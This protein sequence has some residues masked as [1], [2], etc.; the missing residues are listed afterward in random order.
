ME[1]HI[2][3]INTSVITGFPVLTYVETFSRIYIRRTLVFFYKKTFL[4]ILPT[5]TTKILC[6]WYVDAFLLT[7][8]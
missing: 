5:A 1:I 4:G 6:R 7:T 8:Q 2:I 3:Q